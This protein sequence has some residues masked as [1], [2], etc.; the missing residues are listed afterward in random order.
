M[1]TIY[2]RIDSDLDSVSVTIVD[3]NVFAT[4][5]MTKAEYVKYVNEADDMPKVEQ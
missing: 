1:T 3:G 5:E 2:S 4:T